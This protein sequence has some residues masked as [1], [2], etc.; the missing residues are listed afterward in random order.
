[1]IIPA[2]FLEIAGFNQC[3]PVA[4]FLMLYSGLNFLIC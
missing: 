4:Y 1:M 3:F 2:C